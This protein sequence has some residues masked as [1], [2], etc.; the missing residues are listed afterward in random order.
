[1][2]RPIIKDGDF[3][4][5]LDYRSKNPKTAQKTLK[6]LKTKNTHNL[7][8]LDAHTDISLAEDNIQSLQKHLED[9]TQTY[10]NNRVITLNLANLYLETE[11]FAKA[12]ALLVSYTRTHPENRLGW[13]LLMQAYYKQ[14]NDLG[15][16]Q[17]SAQ[18]LLIEGKR[19]QAINAL[20]QA[21]KH[22]NTR[23]LLERIDAQIDYI[24]KERLRLIKE[25]S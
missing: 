4:T 6:P 18:L 17:S 12:Q 21:R 8:Y 23:L 16:H 9:L 20:K 2:I 13:A 24:E 5:F 14:R 15:Y 22:A 3:R 11:A 7:F 1:M 19:V 25:F 10:P